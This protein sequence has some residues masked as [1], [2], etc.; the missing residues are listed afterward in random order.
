LRSEDF[1]GELI[2]AQVVEEELGDAI[3]MMLMR[4]VECWRLTLA[5]DLDGSV[6][7]FIHIELV[8]A[9]DIAVVLD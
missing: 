9:E 5:C 1:D 2:F 6:L 3:Y 7:G 4:V 8:F